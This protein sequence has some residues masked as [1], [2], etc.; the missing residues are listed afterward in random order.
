M[1]SAD[2]NLDGV[3]GFVTAAQYRH[4]MSTVISGAHVEFNQMRGDVRVISGGQ[5]TLYGQITGTLTVRSGG[6]A[7]IYGQVV[8]LVIEPGAIVRLDGIVTGNIT[9]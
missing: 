2:S 1:G 7:H 9:D 6:E 4:S 5:L 3:G 8:N